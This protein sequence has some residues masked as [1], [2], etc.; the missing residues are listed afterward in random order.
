MWLLPPPRPPSGP[1]Q[2]CPQLL[3]RQELAFRNTG[4]SRGSMRTGVCSVH[5]WRAW[6][7]DWGR[8]KSTLAGDCIEVVGVGA[9]EW[10][11]V[12]LSLRGHGGASFS[13]CGPGTDHH[14]VSSRTC[15]TGQ[16]CSRSQRKTG[17][18]R[19]PELE[20][21]PHCPCNVPLLPSTDNC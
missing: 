20:E 16:P 4:E 3:G 11:E 17:K 19:Q 12:Q 15:T 14:Q 13:G 10:S 2:T 9:G 21:K 7:P 1:I 18:N 5:T 6:E 8:S